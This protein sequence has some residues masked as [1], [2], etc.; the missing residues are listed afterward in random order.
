MSQFFWVSSQCSDLDINIKPVDSEICLF[1]GLST[2]LRGV[3]FTVHRESSYL[4]LYSVLET[5]RLYGVGSHITA[6]G[7]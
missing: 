7:V 1:E 3:Y 6:F 2:N 4:V 5:C